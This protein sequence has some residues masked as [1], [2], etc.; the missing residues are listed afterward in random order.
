MH[1]SFLLIVLFSFLGLSA[2]SY[3]QEAVRESLEIGDAG[4]AY[5]RSIRLRGIDSDVAYFAPSAPPPDLDIKQEPVKPKP[6]RDGFQTAIDWP[7]G[8][9]AGAVL[10]VIAYIFLR[11]GGGI[12]VSLRRDAQNPDR[13][14]GRS[15]LA[16]PAWAERLGSYQEIVGMKDRRRALVL[17]TQKVLA[18][19]VA[20]NGV[21][22]QRSW[23]GREA[24]QHIPATWTQRDILR[25]LVLASER[26][27]FGGR[28]VSEHEFREHV[29]ACR[30]ILG[31]EAS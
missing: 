5:L 2:P 19:V 23:T 14:H 1:P 27:Q 21:L 12:A 8:L 11:F 3:G 17:L 13:K 7:T 30:Q 25:S 29:F 28:D 18:S 9:I 20:A 16:T 4:K 6:E 24:L 31:P 10:I 26:V 15:P 22:M